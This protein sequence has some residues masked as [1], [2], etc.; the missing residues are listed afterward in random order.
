MTTFVG[1][2]LLLLP[3]LVGWAQFARS[4]GSRRAAC[5]GLGGLLLVGGAWGVLHLDQ[6]RG[7][8]PVPPQRVASLPSTACLK[9]H[10]E[11]YH[12]WHRS[13]HR[14]MTRE[15]TPDNVKGD[16]DDAT[17][18]FLNVASRMTREG[19]HFYMETLDPAWAAR[20]APP[21][22]SASEGIPA[23]ALRAGVGTVPAL[24]LRAGGAAQQPP[25]AAQWAAA[26]RKKLRVD[27]LVGSHW[28]QECLHRDDTGRYWRLPLSYHIVEQRWVHT[29]SAFLAP[30][31]DDFYSKSTVW[32]E[33]CVFCHNT[34]PS[35]NPRSRGAPG[36]GLR[37]TAES[38]PG[39]DTEVT[40]LGI[41]CEAC[42]GPGERHAR[43]NRNPARRLAVRGAGAGD[44][45]IVNPR[46]LPP[47]RAD[48]IC[49]RCHGATVPRADAWDARTAADPYHAGQ[50]LART[51]LLFW[52]ETEQDLLARGRRPVPPPPP[53]PLDG[54][55]WPD[56][57]PLTTA[58]EYQG[59]ALSPCYEQGNGRLS[60]L[61]CH[62]MH[63]SDPNFQ[64]A[65]GMETNEA[66]YQCHDAYRGRL[67]EHTHHPAGSPGSLCYNCHM[68]HQVY[69]LLTTHRSHR[70]ATPR[71]KDS[72]G[73]GK[74]HACN[75]CHLDKPLGWTQEWLGRWYG[76][77]A[78]ALPEDEKRFAS[79]VLHL[80]QGDARSRVVAAGA[81]SWPPARQASGRDWMAPVLLRALE[82][83]RYP[84]VRYL[85]HRALRSL[86][87]AAAEGYNYE[88]GPGERAAQLA[89]LRRRLLERRGVTGGL[90]PRRSQDRR[91]DAG[92]LAV[93]DEA[94]ARRLLSR[95]KDPDV[96]VNE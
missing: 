48:E 36:P 19:D 67:A 51:H 42:H 56:G 81:F 49:A 21:A 55:F 27:R 11:Q 24:A 30:D 38:A 72:L 7:R 22:R 50:E 8:H 57:T 70:I 13:F 33:S 95:R 91:A 71:V 43:L 74:P 62:S 63:Q 45:S 65:R 31:S 83:E 60:C 25:P 35:K 90:T 64:L 34:R 29:N 82:D 87:G 6:R 85:A 1:F 68:P 84:A 66:C 40:E 76:H 28:F 88:G 44:P 58:V 89:A 4:V 23:L 41:A 77:K 46:R 54:R 93:P 59:M 10:E 20:A 78:V 53:G 79:S 16:F 39:Y 32:N 18:R 14:T 37:P 73:T 86:H 17:H 5:L 75:L 92:P 69:S 96:V 61:S 15:A 52:S 80:W 3:V 47:R 9:C 94:A 2:L 26:P 12:S